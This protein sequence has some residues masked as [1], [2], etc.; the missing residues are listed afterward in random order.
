MSKFPKV[1]VLCRN[2]PPAPTGASVVIGNLARQFR[3]HEMVI[4][5]SYYVHTPPQQWSPEWPALKYAIVQL[6]NGWRGAR[7]LRWIQ[8]PLL[9]LRAGLTMLTEGCQAIIVVFPDEVFLLVAYLL[10]RLTNK[11]VFPYLLNT[12][13][14]NR[15][16]NRLARWLQPRIFRLAT[17]VFVMSEGMRRLYQNNYPGL[18]C[19]ALVHSSNERIPEVDEIVSP[20]MHEPIRLVMFGNVGPSNA[21]AA[22]RFAEMARS[23]P[24]LRL[25][26]FSGTSRSYLKQ[27]GLSGD[28]ITVETVSYDVL[29]ER[30]KQS[31]VILL[32]H[33]FSGPT[34][35]EEI[36]TIFPTRTIEALL[37]QRPILA[38]TPPNCFLSEFLRQHEC[39]RIVDEADVGA[40]MR[41][42]AELREDPE[43]RVRLVRRALLAAE[44]FQAGTVAAHLRK[45]VTRTIDSAPTTARTEPHDLR[46]SE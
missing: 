3:P 27:L 21:D 1:I 24:D 32:P 29:M 8:F 31:D 37:S 2:I 39:A 30:L 36:V 20:P 46:A 7:W 41:A 6:P 28:N 34:A 26:V 19:S 40:L 45:V 38:H 22:R 43:L 35:D 15:P 4:V 12:Y 16:G 10:A 14:E 9:L 18:P 11:P 42:V 13:L 23:S 17:H 25:T 5:G 33:G 44:Q